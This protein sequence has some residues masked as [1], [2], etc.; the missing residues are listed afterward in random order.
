MGDPSQGSLNTGAGLPW[1]KSDEKTQGTLTTGAGTPWG[2]G[3]QK[4]TW[5]PADSAL[6][7][8][9]GTPWGASG[10]KGVLNTVSWKDPFGT[11]SSAAKLAGHGAPATELPTPPPVTTTTAPSGPA[12]TMGSR[13][14]TLPSYRD[15]AAE[16]A[17]KNS[18]MNSLKPNYGFSFQA[19]TNPNKAATVPT[20][21]V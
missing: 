3:D 6:G 15:N 9:K 14:G 5:N 20:K 12:P 8:G 2:A 4:G 21:A 11:Q 18:Y 16:E 17:F 19:Q 1:G 13:I 7:T 10:E